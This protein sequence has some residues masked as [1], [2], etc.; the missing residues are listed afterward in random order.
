LYIFYFWQLKIQPAGN[1]A[2]PCG[3]FFSWLF[4]VA[5]GYINFLLEGN[6]NLQPPLNALL[7]SRSD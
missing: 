2:C 7:N 3:M 6:L 4:W 5:G 1:I